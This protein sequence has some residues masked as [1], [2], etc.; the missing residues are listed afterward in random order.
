[1]K[2]SLLAFLYV[3]FINFG[4]LCEVLIVVRMK[5]HRVKGGFP[6][7][8]C[9]FI[10]VQ[11]NNHYQLPIIELSFNFSTCCLQNIIHFNIVLTC[12]LL[13][14]SL[15]FCT[16]YGFLFSNIKLF[17]VKFFN[18][19]HHVYM[20]LESIISHKSPSDWMI[21][22]YLNK[23]SVIIIVS[24]STIFIIFPMFHHPFIQFY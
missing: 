8:P 17:C 16:C 9:N 6:N 10:G 21:S 19:L 7:Q 15:I 18:N 20:I 23:T 14:V 13:V 4:T 5:I 11:I 12:L 1:M 22:N 2:I 24:G 3:W